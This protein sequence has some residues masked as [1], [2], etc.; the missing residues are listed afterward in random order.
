MR[1]ALKKRA[2]LLAMVSICL[3]AL[4]SPLARAQP[5]SP[6]YSYDMSFD[7]D[8]VTTVEIRYNGGAP[9]S[10]SSWVA[11]PKNFTRT[12]TPLAGEI[13]SL[14]YLQ[15]RVGGEQGTNL[16]Y[17][18]MTFSYSSG[19]APFSMRVSFNLT[20]GAM[21]VEPNGL[22]YS[23]LIG[24]PQSATV[25]AKLTLPEGVTD[26]RDAEP[27]PASVDD[28]RSR[29]NLLF[30]VTSE[31]RIAVTFKVPWAMQTDRIGE[32]NIEADVP[33]R[34][35]DLGNRVVAL[36]RNAVPL[37]DDLFKKSVDR[38]SVKFFVPLTFQQF[39]IGGYTPID[40]STFRTGSIFL[41]VL[42][43]RS[44]PGMI[45]TIAI[46]E[47]THQYE[48]GAG[49]SPELLWVQEGLANYVAVQMAKA[50]GY[51]AAS[52]E[53]DLEA[54]A[55]E[56]NGQYGAI[57]QW[58]TDTISSLFQYY[59]ASYEIFRT[60]G[61]QYGDLSFYSRFFH[62]VAELKDG[63][64]STNVAVCQLGVAAGVD[65]SPE[66]TN[67]GFELVDLSGIRT[68]IARLRAEASWYG[69]LLPFRQQA[70]DHLDLAQSSIDTAPEVAT[71]HVR[72][73]AFYIE[74]VP[75]I[76]AG[77]LLVLILLVAIAVIAGRRNGRKHAQ[78]EPS[79]TS[80]Q[81]P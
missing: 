39:G 67:W 71:G 40:A 21:I 78:K 29:V 31:T 23:P 13:T 12:V 17:D 35:A 2:V 41:N 76:I 25:E 68:E 28:S 56:L 32:A 27:T 6:S 73:A 51:D 59:A 47:L 61:E 9:G 26:V 70:L 74:T 10:G 49:I 43:V 66:F 46:H 18:N 14:A 81:S 55:R 77:V 3:F 34:Y 53:A 33:S 72:I 58:R 62:G 30:R 36:C 48:A 22:F 57:Q 15:Y 24:V 50:L 64:R 4:Y 79:V 8:G 7:S 1:I 65:L 80:Q 44:S 5:S 42:Y 69:P 11:V 52:T 60:L 75:M 63:L 38:I 54:T 20:D 37:M 16:F 19:N 45:E